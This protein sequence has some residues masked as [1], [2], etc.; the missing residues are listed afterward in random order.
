MKK[1]LLEIK[2]V[3]APDHSFSKNEIFFERVLLRESFPLH[4]HGFCEIEYIFKGRAEEILNGVR[5]DIS[6]GD[7]HI[8]GPSDFH[9][10][11]IKDEPVLIYKACFDLNL[12]DPALSSGLLSLSHMPILSLDGEKRKL[13]EKIFLSMESADACIADRATLQSVYCGLTNSLIASVVFLAEDLDQDLSTARYDETICTVMN[14][15]HKDFCTGV[16]LSKLANAVYLSPS[17]LSRKFHSSVG[18]S[19]GDYVK[20]LRMDM[21]A[22]L[23]VSTDCSITEICYEVGFVSLSTFSLEFKRIYGVAPSEYRRIN[24]KP[25]ADY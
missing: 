7:I 10:I 4:W 12:I 19:I 6:A 16:N 22:R 25:K 13:V 3:E 21:V 23:L 24:Q 15:I 20:R 18:M 5:I 17:H 11:I 1:R 14:L 9:E 8:L 2:R